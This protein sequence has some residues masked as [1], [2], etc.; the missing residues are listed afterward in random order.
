MDKKIYRIGEIM[1]FTLGQVIIFISILLIGRTG[2]I[3]ILLFVL[4]LIFYRINNI[5][6][7]SRA[8]RKS[9]KLIFAFIIFAIIG[10]MTVNFSKYK[11]NID[12]A[13][14]LVISLT[15]KKTLDRSTSEVLKNHFFLPQ[16]PANLLLG[17]GNFGR[18]PRLPYVRS[19]VG[20]VL[21]INGAG[22][23][24]ML[25]GYSFFFP[26]LYYS[27]KYRWLKPYLSWFITVYLF[28]M[29][30]LNLKDYYFISPV[31][32]SQIYFI[33]ICILGKEIKLEKIKKQEE[34]S[35]CS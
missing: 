6:Q 20:Y 29:I 21:F 27:Y 22:I 15:E 5:I 17:T 25:I 31:G 34:H 12:F 2:L 8:S 13:F 7:N 28:A 19:D 14:E 1:L 11:K 3:V 26:G 33:V 18:S 30:I 23:I 16:K 9:I 24:G 4:A 35:I 32:Y 10:L